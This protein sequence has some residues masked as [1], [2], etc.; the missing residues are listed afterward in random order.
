[1]LPGAK[2]SPIP[3][4]RWPSGPS[5]RARSFTGSQGVI[6][7]ST[8]QRRQDHRL[9]AGA[10]RSDEGRSS[11]AGSGRQPGQQDD[12]HARSR[13]IGHHRRRAGGRAER[14]RLRDLPD[15]DGIF[16]ADPRIVP[17]ARRLDTVT[18]GRCSRWRRPTKVLICA[19]WNTPAATTF[20]SR[21]VVVLRKPGTIV[22]RSIDIPME[23]AILTDRRARPP[24]GSDR[25]RPTR[26]T[27][28]RAQ[29]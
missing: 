11:G 17:N 7:T 8:Q 28:L 23:D 14:R 25:R 24:A 16:T 18:F 29:V 3:W 22:T 21:P 12:H 10:P 5:A 15:V 2:G 9:L 26:R 6:T 1:M 27:G 19:A 4:S 13:R 20:P